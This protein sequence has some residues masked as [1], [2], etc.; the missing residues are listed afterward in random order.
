MPP[1]SGDGQ[2]LAHVALEVGLGNLLLDFHDCREALLLHFFW[3]LIGHATGD[4]AFFLRIGEAAEMAKALL[5][6]K[7]L[8]L[9]KV[10]GEP[11]PP[12][13]G[14]KKRL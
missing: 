1:V 13:Y 6:D 4:G 9:L 2:S 12:K 7:V 3:N 8:Q 10:V 14:A 5:F 11:E